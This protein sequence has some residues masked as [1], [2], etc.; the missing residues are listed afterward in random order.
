VDPKN[1]GKKIQ[2]GG[3]PDLPTRPRGVTDLKKK[4]GSE[5]MAS[6]Q[7]GRPGRGGDGGIRRWVRGVG[8]RA[9]P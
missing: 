1:R 6:K 5:G 3:Q 2:K 4:P 9:D 8:G 7:P